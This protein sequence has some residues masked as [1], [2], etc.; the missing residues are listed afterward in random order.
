MDMRGYLKCDKWIFKYYLSIL[1]SKKW[2]QYL[3]ISM[4]CSV[5]LNLVICYDFAT[6]YF[7]IFTKMFSY[8]D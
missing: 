1:D 3:L 2:E 4:T 6:L 8:S 7:H 5:K